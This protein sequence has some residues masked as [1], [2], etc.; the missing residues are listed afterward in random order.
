MSRVLTKNGAKNG[1][2][3]SRR[4]SV[5]PRD[6]GT[7]SPCKQSGSFLDGPEVAVATTATLAWVLA[8]SILAQLGLINRNLR[9]LSGCQV[10]IFG[11][12]F[13]VYTD[14]L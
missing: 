14:L 10:S 6:L 8:I 9:W 2:D 11:V 7:V 12:Y 1:A 4:V 5:F 3:K 13:G